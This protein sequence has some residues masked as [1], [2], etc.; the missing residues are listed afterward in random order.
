MRRPK[1][2]LPLQA[3][4]RVPPFLSQ[5]TAFNR[6]PPSKCDGTSPLGRWLQLMP[7]PQAGIFRCEPSPPATGL[8]P[9]PRVAFLSRESQRPEPPP[10]LAGPL[11]DPRKSRPN[12]SE[13][14]C[15]I[16]VR[17]NHPPLS[18][19]VRVREWVSHSCSHNSILP[20]S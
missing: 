2:A 13:E 18:V 11:L 20:I 1:D 8:R 14:G 6:W 12:P 7:S 19:L 10:L 17:P 3:V 9:Q 16:Y 4:C 15:T 5:P